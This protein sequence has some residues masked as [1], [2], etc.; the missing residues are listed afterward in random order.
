MKQKQVD[1]KFN[2]ESTF[3]RDVYK[4]K[5]VT[6]TIL[7]QRMNVALKFIEELSFQKTARI[8]EIGCGAGFLSATLAKKGFT[9]EAIDSASSI[10]KLAKYHIKKKNL[11]RQVHVTFGDVHKL[12]F[13]DHSFDLVIAI[14]VIGWLH[15]L[16]KGIAEISRIL[17]SGGY[18]IISIQNSRRW[19]VD[20]P[21]FFLGILKKNL[22]KVG[23]ITP[24]YGT[25]TQY[26]S[27][28]NFQQ[29]IL[30]ARLVPVK[31]SSLGFGP[32]SLLGRNILSD[33]VGIKINQNL[34][35]QADSGCLILRWFASQH[36]FL[37]LKIKKD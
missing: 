24:F 5:D 16:P 17:K 10:I 21:V 36:V 23:V 27:I 20:L 14:G 4:Q 30:T 2:I 28:K 31:R 26:Y 11:S 12:T 13:D 37:F 19:W 33:H 3:W 15:D 32:F 8:L 6:G 1:E 7:N 34:Q 22:K 35:N 29:R 25:I 9:V 18:A